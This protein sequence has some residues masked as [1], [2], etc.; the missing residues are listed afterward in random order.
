[1]EH[2]TIPTESFFTFIAEIIRNTLLSFAENK[3]IEVEKIIAQSATENLGFPL[4]WSEATSGS[5]RDAPVTFSNP[6][7]D[8]SGPMEPHPS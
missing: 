2:I 7:M 3:E 4:I 1:M 6:V 5:P 8:L